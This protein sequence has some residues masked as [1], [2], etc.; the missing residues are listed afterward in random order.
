M[1]DEGFTDDLPDDTALRKSIGLQRYPQSEFTPPWAGT[2]PDWMLDLPSGQKAGT[3][4]E[5][6]KA[7]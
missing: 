2:V 4:Q 5:R 6:S 1:Y 3:C 7:K